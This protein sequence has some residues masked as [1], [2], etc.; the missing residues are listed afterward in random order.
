MD[1]TSI[2]T[3]SI[4]AI[5]TVIVALSNIYMNSQR[6]KDK[7]EARQI[8]ERNSAKTS[9]QNM[10]TQDIIRAE[11]LKKMPENRENI[12]KE[13]IDYHENGG[14][15]TVTRQYS[16]YLGWYDEQEKKLQKNKRRATKKA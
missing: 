15:G 4:T 6:K 1:I 11:I 12:E 2:I 3:T 13:Y 14:N 5:A 7:E 16:E 10:I 9:I 8:A